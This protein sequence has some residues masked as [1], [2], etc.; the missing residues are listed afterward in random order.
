MHNKI[1]MFA[2]ATL[3]AACGTTPQSD[4]ASAAGR[5]ENAETR[6]DGSSTASSVSAYKHALAQRIAQVNSIKMYTGRPQALLKSV[7]VIKYTVDADGK[8]VRSEIVRSNRIRENEATAMATLKNTAPFPKPLPA[9]LTHGKIELH[10][11]WLFNNDGRFQLR[12][13]AEPQMDSR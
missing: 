7:V 12:T 8:L 5:A 6:E 9:L 4:G 2:A 1:L 3:L 11:T 13:I 10:E